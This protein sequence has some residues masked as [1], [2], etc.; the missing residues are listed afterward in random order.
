MLSSSK[1]EDVSQN[2]CVFKLADRQTEGQANR[3]TDGQIDRQLQ[4]QQLQ[5][6]LHYTTATTTNV[7]RYI[8][9]H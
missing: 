8:T 3:Q 5:L 1:S 2:Y 4:L 9:L 6:E 7:L